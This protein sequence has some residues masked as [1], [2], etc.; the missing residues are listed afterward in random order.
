MLASCVSIPL[1]YNRFLEN[2]RVE[3]ARQHFF[4]LPGQSVEWDFGEFLCPLCECYGN[5]VLPLLPEV[6]QISVGAE[7]VEPSREINMLEWRELLS[8]A[9]EFGGGNAMDTGQ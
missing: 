6:G 4:P 2:K 7:P 9:L 3:H 8:L 1:P 5:T